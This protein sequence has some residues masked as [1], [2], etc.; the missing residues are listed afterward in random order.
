VCGGHFHAEAIVVLAAMLV[1]NTHQDAVRT[2]SEIGGK[3][4]RPDVRARRNF[5]PR[6]LRCLISGKY[7]SHKRI[8]PRFAA[9]RHRPEFADLVFDGGMPAD[10]DATQH[11]CDSMMNRRPAFLRPSRE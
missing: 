1:N 8:R 4:R 11:L 2:G 7:L 5:S 9:H 10:S 3:T 6:L